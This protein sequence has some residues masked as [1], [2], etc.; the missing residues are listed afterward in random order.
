MKRILVIRTG[1]IGDT[2]L[3][4]PSLKDLERRH[5]GIEIGLAGKPE[6][7]RLVATQLRR[8]RVYD[9]DRDFAWL[10]VEDAAAPKRASD[11]L[12]SQD[13]IVRFAAR[14]GDVFDENLRRLGCRRLSSVA[15]LPPDD[16][17][18]H[19][20]FYPF[21]ALG[22]PSSAETLN[23]CLDEW[24]LPDRPE[25]SPGESGSRSAPRAFA[26]AVVFCPGAGGREKRW[27]LE[28]W[29]RL[30]EAFLT[31]SSKRVI[32]LAGP[33]EEGEPLERLSEN[34]EDRVTLARNL[35]L[36]DLPDLL[37]RVEA[38][39]GHDSG[40]TH[41]AAMMGVATLALFGPTDPRRWGPLG[42]RAWVFRGTT[43]FRYP[44]WIEGA[45]PS[46]STRLETLE[47]EAVLA[48]LESGP[49]EGL[50]TGRS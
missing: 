19:A 47:P 39:V 8:C 18:R 14:P 20:A 42:G 31:R 15:A 26:S 35:S 7:L 9:L 16:Y 4:L 45:S 48:W 22:L 23:A 27:P 5:P 46:G 30:L 3:L 36:D 41:L 38:Y 50:A 32:L 37:S 17:K 34:R 13:W 49:G 11:L 2:L 6:R 28:C 25:A 21:D 10:F 24:S 40:V 29:E 43:L 33:A 44:Q 12:G 1:A